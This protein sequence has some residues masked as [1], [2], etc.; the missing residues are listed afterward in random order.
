MGGRESHERLLNSSSET[1]ANVVLL[2]LAVS[3]LLAAAGLFS[4]HTL[5]LFLRQYARGEEFDLGA[6]YSNQKVLHLINGAQ[7]LLF[8][9]TGLAFLRWTYLHSPRSAGVDG[10]E[11]LL[12]RYRACWVWLVPVLN[13][14]K[15]YGLVRDIWFGGGTESYSEAGTTRRTPWVLPMW[16]F[17]F[18]AAVTLEHTTL[19]LKNILDS[20]PR[21]EAADLAQIMMAVDGLWLAAAALGIAVIVG[22]G[23]HRGARQLDRMDADAPDGAVR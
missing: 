8:L 20:R 10:E 17:T 2:L 3:G 6:F 14:Y 4:N 13:L 16:W 5:W 1:A 7:F 12:S 19:I 15:P 22:V 23:R 11:H 18:L 21:E 9:A